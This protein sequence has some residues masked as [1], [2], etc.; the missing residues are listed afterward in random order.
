MFYHQIRNGIQGYTTRAPPTS[1]Q[2]FTSLVCPETVVLS[3][4]FD[5]NL[6]VPDIAS[7]VQLEE[8][9]VPNPYNALA[10][11]KQSKE[12][13]VVDK[14]EQL[15]ESQMQVGKKVG[16]IPVRN[17]CFAQKILYTEHHVCTEHAECRP[18]SGDFA[19]V[20]PIVFLASPASSARVSRASTCS[21]QSGQSFYSFS[22]PQ[23]M[24]YDTPSC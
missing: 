1:R 4:L 13:K 11:R 12:K 3:M 19:C 5:K 22:A 8:P 7:A 2:C 20:D 24:T 6:T 17:V 15:W 9:K 10:L 16:S 18:C 21:R 14:P 23:G